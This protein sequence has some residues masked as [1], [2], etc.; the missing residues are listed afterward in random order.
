MGLTGLPRM[1]RPPNTW[2]VNL[3]QSIDWKRFEDVVAAYFREKNFRCETV[4]YGADDGID[5]RLYFGDLPTPVGII[6]CKA[7]GRRLVGVAPVR[8]LLGVMAHEKVDRGYFCAT[9]SFTAEAVAFASSNPIKLISGQDFLEAIGNMA[10]E[11]QERLLM[12]CTTGDYTTPTCASC[13]IKLVK[14]T[15][16]GRQ[17]WACRNYPR[18]RMKIWIRA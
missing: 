4:A 7:W 8:E 10:P 14:R 2:S 13:G 16:G 15:I 1:R 5:G 6:Q 18:C 17:A 3:L 12:L 9:G 11:Q